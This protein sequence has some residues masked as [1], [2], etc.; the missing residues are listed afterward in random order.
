[1]QTQRK[2][3]LNID[4]LEF[5]CYHFEV[6][7]KTINKTNLAEGDNI[8]EWQKY[9]TASEV[10]DTYK[11]SGEFSIVNGNGF[12]LDIDPNIKIDEFKNIL[13]ETKDVFFS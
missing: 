11:L 12:T 5:E 6:N 4:G 3:C 7:D 2:E 8:N 9:R 1:M 10:N 13:D